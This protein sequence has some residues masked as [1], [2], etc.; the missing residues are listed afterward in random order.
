M[1]K[2]RDMQRDERKGDSE[3]RYDTHYLEVRV[4]MTFH[5]DRVTEALSDRD[6]GYDSKEKACDCILLRVSVRTSVCRGA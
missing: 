1:V 5:P 6:A 3:E 4:S 2:A